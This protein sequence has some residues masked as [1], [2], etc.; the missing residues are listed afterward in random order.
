MLEA[1]STRPN[2]RALLD[3]AIVPTPHQPVGRER[4]ALRA[5]VY[6]A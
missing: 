1:E 4:T 5:N 2:E 3:V 6:G